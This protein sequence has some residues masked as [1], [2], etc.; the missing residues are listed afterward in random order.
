M[1]PLSSM[2][3]AVLAVA[4]V[5]EVAGLGLAVL[6]ALAAP[7]SPGDPVITFTAAATGQASSALAGTARVRFR[8]HSNPDTC[9]TQADGRCTL[10]IRRD[11]PP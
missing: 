5:T 9:T 11:S 6:P 2:R 7:S 4:V 1:K 10:D 3:A 8:I